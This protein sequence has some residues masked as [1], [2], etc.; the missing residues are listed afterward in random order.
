MLYFD[1]V[2]RQFQ[3]YVETEETTEERRRSGTRD[4]D[5]ILLPLEENVLSDNLGLPMIVV[6]TKV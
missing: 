4:E 2:V 6:V 1:S 5:K 3:E